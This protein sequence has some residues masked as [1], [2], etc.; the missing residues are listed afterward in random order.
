MMVP[1]KKYPTM[2]GAWSW[3]KVVQDKLLEKGW[4]TYKAAHAWVDPKADSE[5]P[6]VLEVKSAYKLPHHV[7]GGDGMKTH[8]GGVRAAMSALMGA[9]GGVKMPAAD[10][11]AVYAH[12]AKHYAE[13]E[14]EPPKFKKC[15]TVEAALPVTH[16]PEGSDV[17]PQ[18]RVALGKTVVEHV[19]PDT[20]DIT[21][22][23]EGLVVI[24]FVLDR[25][26]LEKSLTESKDAVTIP[27]DAVMFATVVG[28][29]LSDEPTTEEELQE[30]V[31][32]AMHGSGPRPSDR[33]LATA[34]KESTDGVVLLR[35]RALGESWNRVAAVAFDPT[36]FNDEQQEH[37]LPAYGGR[38]V[39]PK[40]VQGAMLYELMDAMYFAPE[41][42]TILDPVVDSMYCSELGKSPDEKVQSVVPEALA[43]S[44]KTFFVPF[45]KVQAVPGK[46]MF[47]RSVAYPS[48]RIDSHGEFATEEDLR[49]AAHDFLAFYRTINVEHTAELARGVELVE[50]FMSVADEPEIN[51]TKGDWCVLLRVVEEDTKTE[52]AEGV[53]KGLS[54]E[55]RC[56]KTPGMCKGVEAVQL[57]QI[58][59][60]K[61]SL[62]EHP[63]TRLAFVAKRKGNQEGQSPNQGPGETK[64][65][66]LDMDEFKKLQDAVQAAVVELSRLVKADVPQQIPDYSFKGIENPDAAKL[67]VMERQ[68]SFIAKFLE[69]IT[70]KTKEVVEAVTKHQTKITELEAVVKDRDEQIVGYKDLE[71]TI[72][73]VPEVDQVYQM[74]HEKLTQATA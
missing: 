54:I 64:K 33:E 36:R 44:T 50:S 25:D 9:R 15:V 45:K 2:M 6:D 12:L 71:K 8:W 47:I 1:H 35:G 73:E 3:N 32:K 11:K 61:I 70:V 48:D 74:I 26:L 62:V 49:K 10:R 21:A 38:G 66:G 34:A 37:Y 59:V 63:A 20:A 13:F 18:Y 29:S 72:R 5:H 69:N 4:A 14:K 57:A 24:E 42:Y 28:E 39:K 58:Q 51:A 52:I 19:V 56:A 22:S 17:V 43:K 53:Y 7:M 23:P 68:A 65:K 46:D 30:A 27:A 40:K 67:L 16:D 41:D 60:Y 31:L 55:G